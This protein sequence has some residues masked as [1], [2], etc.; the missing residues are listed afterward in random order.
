MP[1]G[2]KTVSTPMARARGGVWCCGVDPTHAPAP[3]F[4]RPTVAD[5]AAGRS[6]APEPDP[7]RG[8]ARHAHPLSRCARRPSTTSPRASSPECPMTS[9]RRSGDTMGSFGTTTWCPAS[10]ATHTCA[11]GTTAFGSPGPS[12]R[13]S[14]GG[15]THPVPGLFPGDASVA[16]HTHRRFRRVTLAVQNA[17]GTVDGETRSVR[18]ALKAPLWEFPSS[19]SVR[20]FRWTH[21]HHVRNQHKAIAFSVDTTAFVKIMAPMSA[22]ILTNFRKA[23]E[24]SGHNQAAVAEVLGIPRSAISRIES[25]ARRLSA[26]EARAAAHLF[27]V[28]VGWLL[29]EPPAL[30]LERAE[31]R[32]TLEDG[33]REAVSAVLAQ[34]LALCQALERLDPERRARALRA[35]GAGAEP[36]T[37]FLAHLVGHRAAL[38]ERARLRLGE[39]GPAP[40]GA[41]LDGMGYT[42]ATACLPEGLSGLAL[43]GEDLILVAAGESLGRQRFTLA[44]QYGALY[45]AGASPLRRTNARAPLW[46]TCLDTFAATL[47]LPREV[48]VEALRDWRPSNPAVDAALLMRLARR[49]GVSATFMVR[50][51]RASGLL[52]AQSADVLMRFLHEEGSS[53]AEALG[54]APRVFAD[55][56]N[57]SRVRL[58]TCALDRLGRGE[59]L[60]PEVMALIHRADPEL[61][62]GALHALTGAAVPCV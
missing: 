9:A 25:G 10:A 58:R 59:A 54:L 18:E 3:W 11:A 5:R 60:E 55:D 26:T 24:E 14:P 52:D 43:P 34:G 22:T 6:T 57:P 1:R 56:L 41:I 48:I 51:T 36:D 15:T 20:W 31:L 27:D 61:D 23:R 40:L 46:N 12:T 2:S 37:P 33:D 7:E 16:T 44:H 32:G 47:L 19:R 38:D 39:A 8:K 13:R 4:A 45:L 53:L 29:A 50:A 17:S 30:P 21:R 42:V 62:M 49:W 35:K 28:E